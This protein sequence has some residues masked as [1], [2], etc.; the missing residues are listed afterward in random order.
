MLVLNENGEIGLISKSKLIKLT[1]NF[2]TPFFL[3]DID[4]VN[5]KVLEFKKL[6]LLSKFNYKLYYSVKTNY[7]PYILKH[8]NSMNVGLEVISGFEVD[9][10]DKLGL[11]S[12]ETIVNGP[13]KSQKELE[14]IVQCGAIIQLDSLEELKCIREISKNLSKKKT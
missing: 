10:L 3:L 11:L 12:S 4:T 13:S 6:F 14:K 8:L 5:Q 9:I 2:E 7:T 1:K